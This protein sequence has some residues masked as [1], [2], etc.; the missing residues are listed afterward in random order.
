VSLISFALENNGITKSPEVSG[1]LRIDLFALA[2]DSTVKQALK[3]H[4]NFPII[5][6][7]WYEFSTVQN[8]R[9]P[10]KDYSMRS[11][12]AKL[13]AKRREKERWEKGIQQGK[14]FVNTSTTS[15]HDPIESRLILQ[16]TSTI[17][18]EIVSTLFMRLT[19]VEMTK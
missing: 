19:S 10:E 16:Q 6:C 12:Q 4:K 14:K 1:I 11:L 18:I 8:K 2:H 15:L 5:H 17:S 7:D 9:L 13:N 3:R